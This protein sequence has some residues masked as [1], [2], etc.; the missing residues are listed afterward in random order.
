LKSLEKLLLEEK[1][2]AAKKLLDWR[3]R[4]IGVGSIP[5]LGTTN[6]RNKGIREGS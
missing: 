4:Q 2:E 6:F 1:K 3:C 5:I